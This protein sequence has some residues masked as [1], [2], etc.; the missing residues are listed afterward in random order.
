MSVSLAARGSHRAMVEE[1]EKEAIRIALRETARRLR[2]ND[3]QRPYERKKRSRR[4]P[5]PST[6]SF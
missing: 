6:R 5:K 1:E 3:P 4:L 2:S